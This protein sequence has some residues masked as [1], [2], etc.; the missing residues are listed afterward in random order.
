M[1]GIAGGTENDVKLP[2]IYPISFKIDGFKPFLATAHGYA[3][4][5]AVL[6]LVPTL[7][8]TPS[9]HASCRSAAVLKQ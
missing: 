5:Y 2:P 7:Y 8:Q 1:S 6:Y 4:A 3:G 9:A